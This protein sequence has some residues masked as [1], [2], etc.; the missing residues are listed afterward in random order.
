[1]LTAC[2]F[3]Y[4]LAGAMAGPGP[5]DAIV[6]GGGLHGCS[7]ALHLAAK[8]RRVAVVEKH[9]PGRFASGVNAGGVRRLGRHP[10]EIPLS[11]AAL[12]LWQSIRALV[13]DD[14][15]FHAV[16]QVKIAESD[17]DM[18]RL[19]DRAALVRGLGF[20]H[21]EL[22][23]GN[24]LRRLVPGVAGHCLGAIVCRADGAADPARTTRA[25]WRRAEAAGVVFHV[26][27]AVTGIDRRGDLWRVVAGKLALEAP[28]I[29]NC[30]GAWGD[31]IA[32]LLGDRAPLEAAALTM[33]V[34]ARVPRF[35]EPVCGLA[36][37][38]LSFKQ[39]P[40]GTLLIGGGHRGR[41]DRDAE[42]AEPDP[43]ALA[44]SARTVRRIFP[45][46]REVPMV[47]AWCGLEGMMPDDIPVIGPSPNAPGAYHA[48]GFCGHGF[49]LGPLV[50]RLVAEAIVDGRPSL[51]IEAFSI[52]RFA[53]RQNGAR[54][55][56]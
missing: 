50:G 44:A 37:D 47:R 18:K 1:M 43:V 56:H 41:A 53:A 29:V 32:A 24:E 14:C 52:G 6:I 8:G 2:N 9:F 22:V 35:L 11:V 54:H 3:A 26:G 23:G 34:T 16:G 15:G 25:F 48:F 46:L 42:T 38:K 55:V 51:P 4:T 19:E 45:A 21:E 7:T 49:Q 27:V 28:V 20:A 10:A 39:T 31:R 17:A 12:E 33:M 30:A 40:D 13:G 36:G 5:Q